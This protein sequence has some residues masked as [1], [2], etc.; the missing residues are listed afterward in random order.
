[1]CSVCDEFGGLGCPA[2]NE[3]DDEVFIVHC[4]YCGQE[5][6]EDDE[7]LKRHQG[8]YCCC[9]CYANEIAEEKEREAE[10]ALAA[11]FIFNN[12]TYRILNTHF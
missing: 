9:E 2:C 11:E 4:Y 10:S 3:D 8:R 12:L 5:F 6:S 7:E 1:M